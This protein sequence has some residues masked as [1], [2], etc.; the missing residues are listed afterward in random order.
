V[1][2]LSAI[3]ELQLNI[4]DIYDR[5]R[6]KAS[7]IALGGSF[8]LENKILTKILSI[9]YRKNLMTINIVVII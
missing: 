4:D 9:D 2:R 7:L 6:Y 8:L 5:N 3:S 1:V